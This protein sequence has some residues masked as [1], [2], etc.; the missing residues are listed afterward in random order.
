MIASVIYLE[1]N[2]FND[3]KWIV[4][5]VNY[6]ISDSYHYMIVQSLFHFTQGFWF[7]VPVPV[8]GFP[9]N[10]YTIFHL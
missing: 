10:F 4:H 2:T 9:V 6:S 5:A 7:G 8:L 1:N 3:R